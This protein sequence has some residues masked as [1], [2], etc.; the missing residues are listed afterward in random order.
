MAKGSYTFDPS[1]KSDRVKIRY[2][3]LPNSIFHRVIREIELSN[4]E[5][6]DIFKL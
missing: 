3:A 6:L 5:S 1:Y 4:K 2:N